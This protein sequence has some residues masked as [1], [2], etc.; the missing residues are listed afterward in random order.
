MQ[1][2]SF[3][4][5]FYHKKHLYD[6]LSGEVEVFPIH[7]ELGLTNFCNHNCPF[8]YAAD[9]KFAAD[10]RRQKIEIP[11]GRLLEI[12]RRMRELGI[13]ST[14]LVGSGESTLHRDFV[15]IIEG[16]RRLD[17]E[18]GLFTNGSEI[19]GE[20]AQGIVENLTFIRFSFTGAGGE[21]HKKTQG[22]DNYLQIIS[23]IDHLVR[24]RGNRRLPT[25][26]IQFILTEYSA[27]DLFKAV[28][29]AKELGVDY[30]QIK[31][32]FPQRGSKDVRI[33]LDL[34]KALQLAFEAKNL[35]DDRLEI[36]IKPEQMRLVVE[37]IT[38]RPYVKCLGSLTTTVLEA[39]LN[40]YLCSNQKCPAFCYGSLAQDEFT[41]VWL[42]DKRQRMLAELPVN[43]CPAACRMDPLNRIYD[44]ILKG[45]MTVPT[46]LPQPRAEDHIN[47]L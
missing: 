8:C 11:T 30:F 1:R 26:G 47:F 39:D 40:L 25:I 3:E 34:N 5:I 31:P 37:N 4:K 46:E 38:E 21:I 22:A 15:N 9:S 17:V 42:S 6:V 36:H 2:L 33:G 35:Q 14:N 20:I 28:D 19:K 23:N 44:K 29:M 24:L 27:G 32:V 13:R 7:L 43:S 10:A 41:E 12:I 18:I 16:I 45:E